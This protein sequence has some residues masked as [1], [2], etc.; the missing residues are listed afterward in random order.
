MKNVLIIGKNSYIGASF[1][2]YAQGRLNITTVSSRN[3]EWQTTVYAG[4]DCVLYAAGI[5]HQKQ[6]A[7]NKELYY[8]VNRDMP[9]KAARKLKN[10]AVTQAHFIYL[11]SMAVYGRD[12]GEITSDAAPS[13]RNGDH[14]GQS[15]YQAENLLKPLQSDGFKVT[16]IRPPT[17]YGPNCPGNFQKLVKLAM[18]TPLLPVIENK[19]SMIYIDNLSE[20]LALII[21]QGIPGAIC[22]QNAEYVNTAD[23]ME[24]IRRA[25]GKPTRRLPLLGI[26][27]KALQAVAPPLR[28]AFGS[29]YYSQKMQETP[30]QTDY[31][32]LELAES[33]RLSVIK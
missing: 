2:R 17:V 4:Y 32:I 14:Y 7:A 10:E 3:D 11:S 15:K 22:P 13:P 20:L 25:V 8:R 23:M 19:R 24:M 33:V 26:P 9:V 18:A 30:I 16:I 6:T 27:I 28:K 1:M 29:L 5:A 12:K 31:Q 21:E